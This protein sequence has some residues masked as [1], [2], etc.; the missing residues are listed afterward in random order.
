MIWVG[1]SVHRILTLLALTR[2]LQRGEPTCDHAYKLG[3]GMRVR[4]PCKSM[5]FDLTHKY[6]C[7][8]RPKDRNF[9][10]ESTLRGRAKIPTFGNAGTLL[11]HHVIHHFFLKITSKFGQNLEQFERLTAARHQWIRGFHYNTHVTI[12]PNLRI[13]FHNISTRSLAHSFSRQ[14]RIVSQKQENQQQ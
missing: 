1:K 5:D 7:L 6:T 13:P 12:L 14:T 4:F 3:G 11:L 10:K 8:S 2:S 9:K